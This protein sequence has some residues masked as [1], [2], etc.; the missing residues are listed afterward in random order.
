[1]SLERNIHPQHEGTCARIGPPVETGCRI[2]RI[3]DVLIHTD[4]RVETVVLGEGKEIVDSPIKT[5]SADAEGMCDRGVAGK[6]IPEAE[7]VE[8]PSRA[9]EPASPGPA[10]TAAR[11][12]KAARATP[13]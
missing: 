7:G 1:M 4:F 9:A 13:G 2:C 6:G 3:V 12:R 8:G 5:E 10:A 11:G